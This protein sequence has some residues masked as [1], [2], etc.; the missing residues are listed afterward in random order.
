MALKN[1]PE[2]NHKVSKKA[3]QCPQC[4]NILKKPQ[5]GLFGKL[6]KLLFILFNLFMLFW[7]FSFGDAVIKTDT[8]YLSDA[9]KTGTAIGTGLG[10]TFQLII[11]SV[12]NFILGT[13]TFFTRAK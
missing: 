11:W 3:M 5:R 13:L 6:F 10:F 8:T 7:F 2:C 1:C 9:E 12:G 4:G